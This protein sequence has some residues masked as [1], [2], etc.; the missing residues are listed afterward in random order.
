MLPFRNPAR[1]RWRQLAW[2]FLAVYYCVDGREHVGVKEPPNFQA[3]PEARGARRSCF[4]RTKGTDAGLSHAGAFGFLPTNVIHKIVGV[5]G[6]IVVRVVPHLDAAKPQRL[7]NRW[8]ERL[9]SRTETDRRG[10]HEWLS[11][12]MSLGHSVSLPT[13]V[14]RHV[15]I[16]GQ[17]E[18]VDAA[19]V[20]FVNHVS[21][22]VVVGVG[23]DADAVSPLEQPNEIYLAHGNSKDSCSMP[24]ISGKSRPITQRISNF[25]V[26]SAV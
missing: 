3:K 17:F 26:V 19:L 9:L 20:A 24:R 16:D 12:A 6:R 2:L 18:Q 8:A 11:L 22:D 14:R 7:V 1:S 23:H 25:G 13:P 15:G 4:F 10:C 21:S 5:V